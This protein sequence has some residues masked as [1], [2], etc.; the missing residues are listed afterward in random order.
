MKKTLLVISIILTIIVTFANSYDVR[1]VEELSYVIAIGLDKSDSAEEPIELTVQI[2]EPAPSESGGSKIKTN[3]KTVTCNSINIGLSMLNLLDDKE[4]NLSHCTVIII[5]E[6]L[7]KEGVE[8]FVNT[9]TN[10]IEI[11]PTC[12]ILVSQNPVSEFLETTSKIEDISSKFYNSF[13]NSTKTISYVT[14]CKLSD[15]YSALNHDIKDPIALYSFVQESTI[16]SLG[17]AVFKNGKM[18]GR[19]SGL[20][21][22]CYNIVTN[23]FEEAII[24]I[25]NPYYSPRPVTVNI[26]HLKDT[27]ISLDLENGIPIITCKV[28]VEA[29]ILSGSKNYDFSNHEALL[30]FESEINKFLEN[31]ISEFLYKISREYQTDIIGFEGYFNKNFLTQEE[32]NQ[33]NWNELYTKSEFTIDAKSYLIS[34][35]L[36]SKY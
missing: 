21:T 7:A 4:L 10:N 2:A 26:S 23:N 14:P 19:L 6:E 8:D 24:E 28:N 15:F 29:T 32:L 1:G 13:I 33:Y 9:L 27:K 31:Y 5:S 36:F 30:Q 12:N 17:L 20:D 3:V 34:A 35:F 11:R 16:E 25:Y 18:V 22:I